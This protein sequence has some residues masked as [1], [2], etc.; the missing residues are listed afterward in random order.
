MPAA[1]ELSTSHE[2]YIPKHRTLVESGGFDV[3]YSKEIDERA[4]RDDIFSY[5]AEYRLQ[6]GRFDYGFTFTQD[7]NGM[8]LSDSRTGESMNEKTKRAILQKKGERQDSTREEADDLGLTRMTS[9]ISRSKVGD[10]IWWASL[11]GDGFGDYAFIF[12]GQVV[13]SLEVIDR[14][15]NEVKKIKKQIEMSAIRVENPDLAK[16]N[17]AYQNLTGVDL[18]AN[19]SEDLLVKP[20]LVSATSKDSLEASIREQFEVNGGE[21]EKAWIESCRAEFTRLSDEFVELVKSGASVWKKLEAIHTME[22]HADRLRKMHERGEAIDFNYLPSLEIMT[23]QY[24]NIALEHAA[25]SCPMGKKSSNAF[26]SDINSLMEAI[27]GESG[28][29][30]C[31]KSTEDSHYHCPDCKKE[32]KSEMDRTNFERTKKCKCGFQFGC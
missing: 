19:T 7:E 11:P 22:K 28:I 30:E 14:V 4:L 8:E 20:V 10:A 16:F 18:G 9:E 3:E 23:Y 12:L 2:Q 25:G 27:F 21:D 31:G 17:L 15:T 29:C 1:A 32:Y 26:G 24:R 5:L 13:R 6:V